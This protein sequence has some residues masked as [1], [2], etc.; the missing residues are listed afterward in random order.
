MTAFFRSTLDYRFSSAYLKSFRRVERVHLIYFSS[1]ALAGFPK[2]KL[3]NVSLD[4][5]FRLDSFQTL[6]WTPYVWTSTKLKFGLLRLDSCQTKVWAPVAKLKFGLLL[7]TENWN[8]VVLF[9]RVRGFYL[10]SDGAVN[11]VF[12]F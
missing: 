1:E 8:D 12:Q 7:I 3:P 11:R 10:K 4:D 2:L 6:V 5:S 9:L